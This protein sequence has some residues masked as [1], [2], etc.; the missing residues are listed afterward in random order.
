MVAT[1]YEGV[2][3]RKHSLAVRGAS[4]DALSG[5]LKVKPQDFTPGVPVY[6]LMEVM[7]GPV[8]FDPMDEG[9]AWEHVQITKAA[10]GTIIDADVALPYLNEVTV[11]LEDL[12]V[13]ETGQERLS[14]D[15]SEDVASHEL[16][17]HKRKRERC[18]LCNP[19]TDEEIARLDAYTAAG[20]A[21]GDGE[22]DADS[23]TRPATKRRSR[24][25]K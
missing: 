22:G 18:P 15:D 17:M 11:A 16:G 3:I 14:L 10:R 23:P 20:A 1:E 25:K 21:H 12:R 13:Q 2:P 8:R 4:G 24:P 9:D 7:P 19:K 6:V 5:V